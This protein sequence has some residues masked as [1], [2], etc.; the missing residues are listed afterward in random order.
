M[1]V[2]LFKVRWNKI[3]KSLLGTVDYLC[4]A[5]LT[6]KVE[7]KAFVKLGIFFWWVSGGGGLK[8]PKLQADIDGVYGYIC[9]MI[10]YF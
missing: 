2:I 3:D 6:T 1:H 8:T 5:L 4:L 10:F 7:D 9:G